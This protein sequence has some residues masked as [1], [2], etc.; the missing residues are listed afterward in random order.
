MS[1]NEEFRGYTLGL[2]QYLKNQTSTSPIKL[3]MAMQVKDEVDIIEMNIRYHASKGCEAFFI[4]DNGSKD[5]TR[6]LLA[7]LQS[8]FDLTILDDK[9]P[10]HNQS[11]NMTKLTNLARKSGY[12]WVIENDADEFWF[13]KS[14]DLRSGLDRK[15]SV[16][17]VNRYNVL[18]VLNSHERWIESPWHTLNTIHFDMF[19]DYDKGRNNFLFAPVLHK[20][21]VNAHGVINVGGGNHGA[22]HIGDKLKKRKFSGWNDNLRIFHYALRSFERFKTKVENINRSLKYTAD[23]NYK[24]HNFGPQ[25]LYWNSAYEKGKLEEV[26]QEMLLDESCIDCMKKLKLIQ[27]DDA[28]VEDL[29]KERLI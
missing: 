25:A 21:M 29:K 26:Y 7:Q 15:N 12:D 6:E 4:V 9:T 16:L 27:F 23:N 17:R 10:D 20:V 5:G 2:F 19:S 11:A 14:G 13:S 22:R 3:C 28:L 8:E 18:P 1:F 24:K